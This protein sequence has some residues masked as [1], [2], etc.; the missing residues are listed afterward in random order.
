MPAAAGQ[1]DSHSVEEQ[2][3]SV[4]PWD[5]TLRQVSPGPFRGRMQFASLGDILIYRDCWS[6]RT[7]AGAPCRG[8]ILCLAPAPG[9]QA[10]TGIRRVR[11]RQNQRTPIRATAGSQPAQSGAGLSGIPGYHA[12]AVPQ[13]PPH[14]RRT[15]RITTTSTEIALRDASR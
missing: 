1:L 4:D 5:V 10:R 14:A 11:A 15:Q 2:A 12:K 3:A 13:L 7:V 6:Q 9:P 8:A